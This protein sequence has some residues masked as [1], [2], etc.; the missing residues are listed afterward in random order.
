MPRRRFVP[1]MLGL[2]VATTSLVATILV[3]ST[4]A[5]AA[6]PWAKLVNFKRIEAKSGTDYP[7]GEEHGP[8]LILAT[9]F[10]GPEAQQDAQKLVYELR[11]DYKLNAY[12]HE[13]SYDYS[14]SFVGRGV[15]KFGHP[16]KMRHQNNERFNEVAVLIGD[17]VTVDDPKAKNTLERI[18]TMRPQTLDPNGKKESQD[19]FTAIRQFHNKVW[20]KDGTQKQRGPM[21]MAFVIPN[22]KLSKNYFKPKGIDKFVE[23]LNKGRPYSL[24]KCGK[25]YTVRVATYTGGTLTQLKK[26]DKT[27]GDATATSRLDKAGKSADRLAAKL[28]ERGVEAY[29]FHDRTQSIVTVGGFDSHGAQRVKDGTL[30]FDPAVQ[31]VIDYFAPIRPG[32]SPVQHASFAQGQKDKKWKDGFYDAE[33][34]SG[35]PG[36]NGMARYRTFDGTPFDIQPTVI[37]VPKRSIA[38][39]YA[40][41][42]K[43]F[44]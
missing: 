25:A 29:V 23:D 5:E 14:K 38:S 20:R 24:L 26:N 43:L 18:K 39:D 36:L 31:Q 28:R 11:K 3:T 1:T 13:K 42:P 44:R 2:F 7:V 8:W 35:I 30:R 22:P 17:F 16:R 19:S 34:T 41:L 32:S 40:G 12:T 27:M 4:V 37:D 21:R 10:R 6:P 33:V 9:T 15:D